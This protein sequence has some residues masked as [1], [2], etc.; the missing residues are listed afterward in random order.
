MLNLFA[1]LLDSNL[2]VHEV[3]SL[4]LVGTSLLR[5]D[6]FIF[7]DFVHMTHIEKML[8]RGPSFQLL[9]LLREPPPTLKGV[10]NRVTTH[11]VNNTQVLLFR[12]F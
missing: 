7:V 11:I 4:P 9:G 10:L 8:L 12:L 6:V 3:L 5:P 1:D 2:L